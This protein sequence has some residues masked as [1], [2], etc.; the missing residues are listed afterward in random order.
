MIHKNLL[1]IITS[2]IFLSCTAFQKYNPDF[3]LTSEYII[4]KNEILSAQKPMGWKQIIDTSL[5]HN[6][7]FLLVNANST[8]MISL[9]EIKC[10]S[11][12]LSHL[13]ENN[14][15]LIAE[16]SS[17]FNKASY[18]KYYY[19]TK[20][21]L[22]KIEN[23]EFCGYE[24]YCDYSSKRTRVVVFKISNRYYECIARPISGTMRESE[25]RKLY[26]AM[27]SFLKSLKLLKAD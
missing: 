17:A 22:F 3:P 26:N 12:T 9:Q 21:K 19:A 6:F 18:S 2:T 24:F 27:H 11:N 23:R 20:P 10:D 1:F 5:N 4:S 25:L 15:C 8:S 16:I 7:I 14:L 13:E